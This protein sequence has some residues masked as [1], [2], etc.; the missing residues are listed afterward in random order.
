MQNRNFLFS[1]LLPVGNYINFNGNIVRSHEPVITAE[2]R[3]LRYGDGI[4]ETMR[5]AGDSI[6]LST[7]HFDRLFSGIQLLQFDQPAFFTRE[8]L[9]QQIN[10]LCSINNHRPWARVRLTVF[11]GKGGLY[12]PENHIPNYIIDS[13]PLAAYNESI[14]KEGLV[15]DI[16][17]DARKSMDVFSNLKSNNYLLYAMGALYAK[18]NQLNDCLLLNSQDRICDSTIANIFCVKDKTVFTPYL[19]EGCVSGV[20]RR[21]LLIKLAEAG[22]SVQEKE[23]EVDWLQTVDEI[24]LTNSIYGIRWVQYL[25]DR[26]FKNEITSSIYQRVIKNI[27]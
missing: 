15:I 27:D 3:G 17:P 6:V 12:D 5:I 9:T 16:F 24:F 21:Y 25:R 11:R 22:F 4:F 23:I 26:S 7:F 20:M 19:S 8:I 10:D 1:E 14:N 2:S 13:Q 18:K